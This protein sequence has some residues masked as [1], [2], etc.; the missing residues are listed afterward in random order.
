MYGCIVTWRLE[1]RRCHRLWNDSRG[2]QLHRCCVRLALEAL[3]GFT[4]GG[5]TIHPCEAL[6]G[7]VFE[8]TREAI[9]GREGGL[10]EATLSPFRVYMQ[11]VYPLF[12]LFLL[13]GGER[14]EG[15]RWFLAI[16]YDTR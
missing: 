7:D 5:M 4:E 2:R 1:S 12:E 13:E 8:A 15:L 14:L 10:E 3:G 6:G 16:F 9:E 11:G